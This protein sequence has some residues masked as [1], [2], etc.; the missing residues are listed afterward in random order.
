M[1]QRY[2]YMISYVHNLVLANLATITFNNMHHPP[3]VDTKRFIIFPLNAATT[4][5]TTTTI[6]TREVFVNKYE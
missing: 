5:P 1:V 2:P 3:A 4:A 6:E